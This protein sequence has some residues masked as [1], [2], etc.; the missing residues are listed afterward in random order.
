MATDQDDSQPT[1]PP[2]AGGTV[3]A[4]LVILLVVGLVV[5][6]QRPPA[7]PQPSDG[8]LAK[9]SFEFQ[10]RYLVGAAT[11]LGDRAAAPIREY[12]E[13]SKPLTDW[14]QLRVAVLAGEL[15]GPDAALEKLRATEEP[16]EAAGPQADHTASR[17]VLVRLFRDYAEDEL[18]A[19][20]VS[21]AERDRLEA[22]LGWFGRL[23]LAPPGDQSRLRDHAC[24]VAPVV[25]ESVFRGLLYRH[26]R[27]ATSS[28]RLWV[29]VL[30]SAIITSVLFAI[31]HPQ[32]LLAAPGIIGIGLALV[33]MREWRRSLVP[34]MVAH[35][36]NNGIM[37][38]L[39]TAILTA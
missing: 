11:V 35:G 30:L 36:L 31:L 21:H 29:S 32:G 3:A 12:L 38:L 19:P 26:L 37:L 18:S 5:V 14:Q 9:A 34:S 39:L 23:A 27:E 20:L 22:R 28:A 13:K 10:A 1:K 24:F 6:A 25:E 16:S 15:S 7:R 8:R 4:W 33:F 17:D 2:S